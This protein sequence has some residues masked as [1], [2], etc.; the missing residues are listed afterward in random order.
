MRPR[1]YATEKALLAATE[2][3]NLTLLDDGGVN[4]PFLLARED[5]EGWADGRKQFRMDQFYAWMRKRFEI[6]LEP[7][8]NQQVENGLM[9]RTIGTMPGEPRLRKSD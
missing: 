1:E 5:F 3:L 9:M 4:R 2:E 6:L 7:G 8:E